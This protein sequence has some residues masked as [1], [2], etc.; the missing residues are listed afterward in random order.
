MFGPYAHR[1]AFGTLAEA[2]SGLAHQTGQPDGPPTL[3]PFG[4]ADGV[5]AITGAY[6]VILAL[7]HRDAAGGGRQVIDL[8]LL[9]PLL[10]ILGPGP[11]AYDQL[12][13]VPHRHGNRSTNNAP[14]NAYRTSDGR[15][16]AI[17]AS[18]SSVAARVMA[19]VGRPDIADE[20]W[21]PSA[22]E[23]VARADMLDAIVDGW[24]GAHDFDAV[25]DAFEDAGAAIAPIYD[26]EQLVNDPH[27]RAAE[28]ITTVEDDDL[29]TLQMQN[30]SFRMLGTPG[31]IRFTGRG[32]GQDTEE[33]FGERLG[34][35]AD[36]LAELREKGVI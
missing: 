20:D 24:V 6:A 1:R 22:R 5:A 18:A 23:R 31:R 27:V 26:M 16:V 15:W 19:V 13:A 17:S 25:M 36:R 12:G 28:L 32:P 35:D 10:S 4:L 3:P 29:G 7:Y 30:L 33:V 14:R 2:M 21:F 8:S 34:L 11:S 9:A